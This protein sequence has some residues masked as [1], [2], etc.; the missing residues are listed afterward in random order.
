MALTT[1]GAIIGGAAIGG[2]ASMMASNK[3]S[4]AQ[5]AAAQ[6]GSDTQLEMFYQ[7]REDQAPWR[8]AGQ[9]ALNKQMGMLGLS[10]PMQGQVFG[11]TAPVDPYPGKTLEQL[12]SSVPQ[13]GGRWGFVKKHLAEGMIQDKQN[14]LDQLSQY[15]QD[16]SAFDQSVQSNPLDVTAELSSTPGY[17]FQVNEGLKAL[18]RKLGPAGNS[19]ATQKAMLRYSQGLADQTFNTRLNQLAALSGTGQATAT[20]MGSQGIATGGNLANLA[21]MGGNAKAGGYINQSNAINNMIDQ[22]AGLFAMSNFNQYAPWQRPMGVGGV[23]QAG[24]LMYDNRF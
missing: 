16:K 8:T 5:Q 12:Q 11:Q 14:Y 18:E 13:G 4:K 19:G 15:N 9:A 24:P 2:G 10:T 3:A 1:A 20:N 21:F 23:E 22:G 6:K 17:Q 7:A